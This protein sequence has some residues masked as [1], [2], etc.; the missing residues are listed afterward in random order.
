[1]AT[2]LQLGTRGEVYARVGHLSRNVARQENGSVKYPGIRMAVDGSEAVVWVEGQL[3]QA[4]CVYA[5]PP[6]NRM[7]ER[8]E[9]EVAKGKRNLW[10]EPVVAQRAESALGAA[11]MCEGFALAGGRATTFTGGQAWCK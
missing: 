9:R 3:S 6:A 5:I 7:A 4:A 2:H 8:F 10:N 11:S 1:V